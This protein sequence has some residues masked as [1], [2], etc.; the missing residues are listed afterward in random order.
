MFVV[1]T[2][3]DLEWVAPLAAMLRERGFDVLEA[4]DPFDALAMAQG[5]AVQALIVHANLGED[6]CALCLRS[7]ARR[8]DPSVRRI[9]IGIKSDFVGDAATDWIQSEF[10][11]LAIVTAVGQPAAPRGETTSANLATSGNGAAPNP[12]PAPPTAGQPQTS[13]VAAFDSIAAASGIL[14]ESS[15]ATAVSSQSAARPAVQ[16]TRSGSHTGARINAAAPQTSA[17]A[18]HAAAANTSDA[19]PEPAPFPDAGPVTLTQIHRMLQRARFDDYHVLLGVSAN[20]DASRIAQAAD[21]LLSRLEDERI[22][23][24]IHDAA[25]SDLVELRAA[26]EDAAAVLS[27]TAPSELGT[28]R[29]HG[30]SP[31]PTP[32][33]IPPNVTAPLS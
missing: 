29:P 27:I 25:F 4:P 8:L 3:A 17:S 10:R 15:G 12:A 23:A 19:D 21:A 28:A 5:D 20:A 14:S 13:E 9:G 26:V 11:Y 30:A 1:I 31:V 18:A 33:A 32:Q 2:S 7:A 24:H 22:P 6:E 16:P